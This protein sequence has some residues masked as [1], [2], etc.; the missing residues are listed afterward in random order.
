[1]LSSI[2]L[3]PAEE[4]LATVAVTLAGDLSRSRCSMELED[5]SSVSAVS[6]LEVGGVNPLLMMVQILS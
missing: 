3:A 1:M 6:P 2:I 5:K 4:A